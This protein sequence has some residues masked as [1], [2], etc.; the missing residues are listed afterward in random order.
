MI[1]EKR[2]HISA[3]A[4]NILD[5]S[6]QRF[7]RSDFHEDARACIVQRAQA[8]HELHWRCDL[9]R[10]NV[11]HLRPDGRARGIKLTVYVRHDRHAR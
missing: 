5:K 6:L 10:E 3:L 7:L 4:E 2:N 9:L 1:G 11:Q 8:L